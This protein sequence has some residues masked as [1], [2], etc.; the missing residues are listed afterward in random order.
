M[1]GRIYD[2]CNIQDGARRPFSWKPLTIITQCSILAV[3][4][5]L[6][7]PLG[8]GKNRYIVLRLRCSRKSLDIN[9]INVR[10]AVMKL[11]KGEETIKTTKEK[12]T[13]KKDAKK[14]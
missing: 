7:P 2:C 4:A 9:F 8:T 3:A 13:I 14:K 12:E 1:K 10:I 11:L 5:V 6:D